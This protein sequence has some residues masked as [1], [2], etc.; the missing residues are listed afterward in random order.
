MLGFS[1]YFGVMKGDNCRLRRGEH[2][3]TR[4]RR[5][6]MMK[7]DDAA[8]GFR[9]VALRK[10]PEMSGNDYK[11]TGGAGWAGPLAAVHR[12]ECLGMSMTVDNSA[13]RAGA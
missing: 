11:N 7:V 2:G 10:C 6:K 9:R 3:R 12:R 5:R 1:R 4:D 8:A 13:S